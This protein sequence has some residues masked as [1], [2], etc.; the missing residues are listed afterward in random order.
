MLQSGMPL[1]LTLCQSRIVLCRTHD[2]LPHYSYIS[3]S[4]DLQRPQSVPHT[5]CWKDT[6]FLGLYIMNSSRKKVNLKYIYLNH[7][8]RSKTSW[9]ASRCTSSLMFFGGAS[10]H[11]VCRQSQSNVRGSFLLNCLANWGRGKTKKKRGFSEICISQKGGNQTIV[12]EMSCI[13]H[14]TYKQTGC[15]HS[16]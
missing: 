10:G 5:H 15:L 2:L 6:A 14:S 11:L 13:I 1:L 7:R 9:T 4:Q 8:Y 12:S 16:P 3:I